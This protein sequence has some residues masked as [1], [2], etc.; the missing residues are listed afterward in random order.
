MGMGTP[1]SPMTPPPS[2]FTRITASSSRKISS[3]MYPLVLNRLPLVTNLKSVHLIDGMLGQ[4]Y[5][6][7]QNK[8]ELLGITS[9][10]IYIYLGL[11]YIP[12]L[13]EGRG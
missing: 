1:C 5:G 8:T 6:I 9:V 10:T 2:S 3:V 13:I 4:Y 7:I 12:K 11:Y